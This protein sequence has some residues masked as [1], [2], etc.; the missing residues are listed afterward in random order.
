MIFARQLEHASEVISLLIRLEFGH[1]LRRY[2]VVRPVDVHVFLIVRERLRLVRVERWILL[3]IINV[4]EAE[5]KVKQMLCNVSHNK[6]ATHA[7]VEAESLRF[8]ELGVRLVIFDTDR[9]SEQLHFLL[10]SLLLALLIF[11][12]LPFLGRVHKS[13]AITV[14]KVS[15]GGFFLLVCS[16]SSYLS[17][18][19]LVV[20]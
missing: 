14:S 17:I 10:V 8:L 18:H 4:L 12:F 15:G 6:V 2:A 13:I 9:L 7:H 16:G 19:V 20:E 11:L 1:P 3:R 5:T